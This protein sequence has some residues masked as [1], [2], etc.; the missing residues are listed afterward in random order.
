MKLTNSI[1]KLTNHKEIKENDTR[2][3]KEGIT[4]RLLQK[5]KTKRNPT[6]VETTK[7][8]QEQKGAK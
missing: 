2:R 1:S 7:N 5:Y 8:R 3:S 6:S 4:M